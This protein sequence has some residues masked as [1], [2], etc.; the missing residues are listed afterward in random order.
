VRFITRSRL[1]AEPELRE[2]NA[3]GRRQVVDDSC[4]HEVADL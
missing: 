1:F 4:S 3:A 2:L